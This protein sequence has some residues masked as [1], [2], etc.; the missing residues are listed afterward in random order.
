MIDAKTAA[1]TAPAR[2]LQEARRS[3]SAAEAAW[4]DIEELL[5]E[6]QRRPGVWRRLNEMA[7]DAPA[8]L[9]H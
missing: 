2:A 4:C 8:P 5:W 1:G 7:D 3:R 9:A 6:I